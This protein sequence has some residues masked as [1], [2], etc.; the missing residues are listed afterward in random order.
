MTPLIGGAIPCINLSSL[1]RLQHAAID[2]GFPV[3]LSTHSMIQG[4]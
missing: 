3:D 1:E 2:D 4:K